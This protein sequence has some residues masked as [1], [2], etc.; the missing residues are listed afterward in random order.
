MIF[1]PCFHSRNV[2]LFRV[3]TR[4]GIIT[5][6]RCLWTLVFK[7]DLVVPLRFLSLISSQTIP[8]HKQCLAD[9]SCCNTRPSQWEFKLFALS[10]MGIWIRLHDDSNF[11]S[12]LLG[13]FPGWKFHL[14]N[15]SRRFHS[16]QH[17]G[18]L[19]GS[20]FFILWWLC[21]RRLSAWKPVDLKRYWIRWVSNCTNSWIL[22][23]V[24]QNNSKLGERQFPLSSVE[25]FLRF[26]WFGS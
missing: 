2:A 9:F 20:Q 1:P 7:H 19:T 11:S 10:R 15:F 23:I 17:F 21:G 14:F 5:A 8:L 6:L 13:F 24:L 16:F 4:E 18:K 22:S 25:I 12:S 26:A 3:H